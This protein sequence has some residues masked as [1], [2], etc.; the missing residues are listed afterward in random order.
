MY[1]PTHMYFVDNYVELERI[2]RFF[3]HTQ[4]EDFL[5]FAKAIKQIW[6]PIRTIHLYSCQRA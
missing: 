4:E 6:Q 1:K 5:F 2:K 3:A